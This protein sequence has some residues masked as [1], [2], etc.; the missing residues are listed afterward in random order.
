MGLHLE[1]DRTSEQD[2]ELVEVVGD[3]AVQRVIGVE[4]LSLALAVR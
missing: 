3:L 4:N 2:V 1:A